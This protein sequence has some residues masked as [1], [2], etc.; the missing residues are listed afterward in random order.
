ML[1]CLTALI[2]LGT[3]LDNAGKFG[4]LVH[5][6]TIE[7]VVAKY[8]REGW[9]GCFA[10]TVREEIGLKPWANSTRIEGFAEAVEGNELMKKWD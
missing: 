2:Q 9:S 4:E 3:L 6:G 8:P 1:T 5:R 7:A 10:G